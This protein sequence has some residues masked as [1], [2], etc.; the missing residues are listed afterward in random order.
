MTG[1]GGSDDGVGGTPQ[2]EGRHAWRADAR[3]RWRQIHKG[4]REAESQE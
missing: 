4:G 3:A 1:R 2:A